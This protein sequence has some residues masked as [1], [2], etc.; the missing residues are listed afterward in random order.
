MV[1]DDA[2]LNIE[3]GRLELAESE[4]ARA[5]KMLPEDPEV[6][7][8]TGRLKLEKAKKAKDK[9]IVDKLNRD[10]AAAFR[11]AVRLDPS[12]PGPHREL[13]LLAYRSG[14]GATACTEFRK[15]LELAPSA[16]DAQSL[17]DY[18]TELKRDGKCP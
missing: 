10:A 14:D 16:D 9:L 18:L 5:S 15:Y 11:E 3:M 2:R 8:L 12:R 1:R 17:R 6:Q 7:Y 4:L 13:G